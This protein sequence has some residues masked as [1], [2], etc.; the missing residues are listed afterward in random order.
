MLCLLILIFTVRNE[1][2]KVM[3]YTC[4]SV[5]LFTGGGSASVHAGIP[6]NPLPQDQAP[7]PPEQAPLPQDQ[8]SRWDQT[9]PPRT[10]HPPGPGIPQDQAPPRTRHPPQQMATVADCTHPTG[11]HSCF[12]LKLTIIALLNI[13]QNKLQSSMFH[14]FWF[15]LFHKRFDK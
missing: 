15:P 12:S 3:F 7:P 1:V 8:A 9:P 10:R 6:H 2:A 4:L 14:T 5:I 11:M 13:F